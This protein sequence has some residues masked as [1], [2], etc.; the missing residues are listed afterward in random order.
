MAES[1]CLDK[2]FGIRHQML[3]WEGVYGH[4]KVFRGNGPGVG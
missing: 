3:W 2:G 1:V 4:R